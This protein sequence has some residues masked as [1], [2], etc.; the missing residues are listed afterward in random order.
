MSTLSSKPTKT[1]KPIELIA[2]FVFL[3]LILTL[4]LIPFTGNV[5]TSLS[6]ALGAG[7]STHA[8]ISHEVNYSFSA[9]QQYWAANCSRGWSSNSTCDAI[10]A[11][12]QSC[13]ISA[14][15]AYCSEYANYL[16]QF[17]N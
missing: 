5:S 4:L 14:D 8:N 11:R 13:S 7:N 15:S 16:K 17:S 6:T 12:S 1:Y 3:A 9:D 10:V 2:L